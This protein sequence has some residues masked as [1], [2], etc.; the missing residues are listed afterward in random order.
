MP[1]SLLTARVYIHGGARG[2]AFDVCQVVLLI[3]G[4]NPAVC[5]SSI[6]QVALDF[7]LRCKKV[8][9][10]T[11]TNFKLRNYSAK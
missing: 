4:S 9:K 2:F 1:A 3:A 5:L 11:K 6:L 10:G 7:L 8:P